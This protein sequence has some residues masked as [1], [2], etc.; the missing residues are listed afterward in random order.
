MLLGLFLKTMLHKYEER[1]KTKLTAVLPK[2]K[3]L[4]MLRDILKNTLAKEGKENNHDEAEEGGE[5][6]FKTLNAQFSQSEN[7]LTLRNEKRKR[8]SMAHTQMRITARRKIKQTK[9]LEKVP[10]FANLDRSLIEELIERMDYK[11]Y[12][13]GDVVCWQNDRSNRFYII[14][15]GACSILVHSTTESIQTSK[16]ALEQRMAKSWDSSSE[17]DDKDGSGGAVGVVVRSGGQRLTE[18]HDLAFFGESCIESKDAT[19]T[20]TVIVSSPVLHMLSLQ[21]KEWDELYE[22]VDDK[23]LKEMEREMMDQYDKS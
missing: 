12:V 6:V 14:V 4:A 1:R 8:T 21:R 17:K 7:G 2:I 18:L 3:S 16:K 10:L 11:K 19:R 13:Y 22:D 15:S 23:I 20:A 5:A 9:A